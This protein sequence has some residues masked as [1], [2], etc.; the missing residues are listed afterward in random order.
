VVPQGDIP[1]LIVAAALRW[2]VDPNL[3]LRIADCESGDQDGDGDGNP[4]AYNRSGASGLFQFVPGTWAT[5]FPQGNIWS[6]AD[7][8]EAAAAKVAQGG[9]SA[10]DA[11]RHCWG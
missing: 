10:W 6:A 4:Q 8:A 2:H 5:T 7:Q 1:N 3:M 9:L 11:S